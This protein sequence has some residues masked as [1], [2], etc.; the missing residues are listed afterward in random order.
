MTQVVAALIRKGGRFMI[1]QRPE[2]KP[3]ALCWEFCGGKVEPGE[4]PAKALVRECMEEIGAE[5]TVDGIYAEVDHVYPDIA[6]HLTVFDCE[7]K[8]GEEPVRLEHNDIRFITPAEADS[9]E[10]CPA[11]RD[12][13]R[14]LKEEAE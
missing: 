13:I 14:K 2:G 11:D 1:C 5:I 10:F 12:I 8:P 6:I 9:F 3:R 4:A 7:L